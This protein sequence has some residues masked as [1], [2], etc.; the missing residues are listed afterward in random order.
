MKY[1][2]IPFLSIFIFAACATE[3]EPDIGP[4]APL[5]Q[6]QPVPVADTRSQYTV[7]LTLSNDVI[8]IELQFGQQSSP[9]SHD[10]RMP[11][12]PPEGILHA[13]FT[14]DSKNYWRDFRSENSEAEEWDFTYQTGAN[15]PVILKWDIQ[16]TRFPG[17]LTLFNPG[18]NSL[19][20][21]EGT[22]EIEL[23]ISASGNLLFEY[24]LNE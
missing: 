17:S 10:E 16:A 8:Q 22:G 2:M 21:M 15:G 1:L 11:P 14:K 7:T 12:H 6:P 13:Y 5:P 24:L 9:S 4:P 3:T 18:D 23:P 20:I 19:V